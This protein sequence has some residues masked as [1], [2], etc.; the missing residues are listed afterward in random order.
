MAKEKNNQEKLSNGSK[1][2]PTKQ[3]SKEVLNYWT[4]K[5]KGEA[6]A[7]VPPKPVFDPNFKHSEFT[8]EGSPI[9]TPLKFPPR[10]ST[11]PEISAAAVPDPNKWPYACIG[12]LYMTMNG[13][14]Y[15]GSAFSVSGSKSVFMTAGHCVYDQGSDSWATNVMIALSYSPT[16]AGAQFAAVNLVTLWGYI[17]KEGQQYDIGAGVVDGDMFTGRGNLGLQFSQPVNTSP[18][19]A[20]GY[21]ANDPFPGNTMYQA[22]GSY[23][24]AGQT[25]TIGMNNN[26][27]GGGS[28][29]GPWMVNSDWG[30]VNG[31]QS[32]H[33]DNPH[34]VEYSPYF[35]TGA[36]NV[37]ACAVANIG[38]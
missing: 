21:P 22:V 10:V 2:Q 25:G 6:I 1:S 32:Y 29:G 19:T 31:L 38:C 13:V 3:N 15:V 37:W 24:G 8:P 28:S 17:R 12:K 26:D 35:G 9:G 27:M 14:N 36:Y 4:E 23:T 20:V 5:R 16:S 18:W 11:A 34:V 33:N 7:V 30:Y